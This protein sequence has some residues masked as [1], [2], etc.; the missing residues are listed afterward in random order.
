M[1][2]KALEREHREKR[3]VLFPIRIDDAVMH[4]DKAWAA[5]IR[6]TLHIGDFSNWRNPDSYRAAFQRLLRDLK[7]EKRQ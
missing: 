6:R 2:L 4:T 1:R 5:S 3:V 7:A